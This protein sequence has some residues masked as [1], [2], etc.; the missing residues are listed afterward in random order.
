LIFRGA[1]DKIRKPE[2]SRQV[3]EPAGAA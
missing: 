3:S 1:G 2:L